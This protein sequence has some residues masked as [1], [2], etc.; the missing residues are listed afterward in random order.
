MAQRQDRAAF[1][2]LY[3]EFAGTV[4]GI[5]LAR[6]PRTDVDDLVQDVF[7]Q[8]MQRLP[9]LREPAAFPSWL[10]TIARHRAVDHFRRA[11]QTT[12]LPEDLTAPDDGRAEAFAVL[13]LIRELPDA[14]RETLTLRLVEGMTGPEIAQATRYGL[15]PI[16]VVVNNGGWQIFR[17][18]VNKPALLDI[19]NWPYAELAQSWGGVGFRAETSRELRDALD[20]AA[21]HKKT[22]VVVEACVAPDDHS[23]ISRKYIQASAGKGRTKGKR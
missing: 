12:E 6:A 19:P 5:L 15:N 8:A 17:P 23:P 4:H 11:P 9:E 21:A 14:Y 20:A 1:A 10:A 2:A 13:A 18:V 3:D 7:L 22:F 16:V